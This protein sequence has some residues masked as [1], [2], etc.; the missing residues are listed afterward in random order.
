MVYVDGDNDLSSYAFQDINTME[1][2]GSTDQVKIV[3]QLDSLGIT[4]TKRYLIMPDSNPFMITSPVIGDPGEVNMGNGSSLTGFIQFS[5]QK[6]PAKKYA[7]VLWNHGGGFRSAGETHILKDICWDESSGNDSLTMPELSQA[8]SSSGVFLNV[9]AMDACLMGMVEVAYQ[10]RNN[11][12]ILVASEES[13]PG[14][15]M[16]YERFLQDLVSSPTMEGSTLAR[17]M[18]D[19]YMNI[20][21]GSGMGVT[22]SSLRLSS[23]SPL[24]TALDQ[25]AGAILSDS[26]SRDLYR[27]IGCRDTIWFS[28]TDFID[29]GNFAQNLINHPSVSGTVKATAQ[30]VLSGLGSAVLY[31]RGSGLNDYNWNLSGVRGLSIYFPYNPYSAKYNELAFAQST[32][33]DNLA[34]FIGSGT[35]KDRASQLRSTSPHAIDE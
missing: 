13:V 15:G 35:G 23:L 20:Y 30:N 34:K 14:E 31:N 17:Y 3:A 11:A 24:I 2:V 6:Y 5:V 16:V 21:S 32:Q 1:F 29:I 26:G 10:V 22:L 7:L 4:G 18:I 33:W 27:E 12:S 19:S 9:L 25:L 28:D 8:L